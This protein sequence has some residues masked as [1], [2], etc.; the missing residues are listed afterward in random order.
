MAS[1]AAVQPKLY[2]YFFQEGN[3]FTYQCQCICIFR[4]I[5]YLLHSQLVHP[6]ITSPSPSY[7]QSNPDNP[8]SIPLNNPY[9]HNSGS[10]QSQAYTLPA[11]PIPLEEA[12]NMNKAT[13]AQLAVLS[14][15][16]KRTD[17]PSEEELNS[18]A[19][20]LGLSER[21]VKNW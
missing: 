6:L 18:L 11:I 4:L 7:A 17:N 13:P 8:Y 19:R 5:Y 2:T 14:E 16:Y 21:S 3:I 12:P 10:S 15:T 20:I 9:S 1:P